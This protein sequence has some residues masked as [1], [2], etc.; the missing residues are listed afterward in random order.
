MSKSQRDAVGSLTTYGR[1]NCLSKVHETAYTP[2]RC[3]KSNNSLRKPRV[4]I[5]QNIEEPEC[6]AK[7][8]LKW[9]RVSYGQQ[10]R[11]GRTWKSVR[12]LWRGFFRGG[13]RG[14][15]FKSWPATCSVSFTQLSTYYYSQYDSHLRPSHYFQRPHVQA[16]PV[17]RF[18]WRSHCY[19]Q[20][21]YQW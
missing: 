8:C 1:S 13:R 10:P 17:R 19:I 2:T 15:V 9:S 11:S 20:G 12:V 7:E 16:P 6:Y 4:H 14:R 21:W 3:K 5:Q 18:L